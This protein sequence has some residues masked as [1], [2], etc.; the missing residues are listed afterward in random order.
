MV[1]GGVVQLPMYV[2]RNRGGSLGSVHGMLTRRMLIA[3][4]VGRLKETLQ[5]T[6]YSVKYTPVHQLPVPTSV[7]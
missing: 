2:E 3:V 1:E 7:G 6:G 5:L 4:L